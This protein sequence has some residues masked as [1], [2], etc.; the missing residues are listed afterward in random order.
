MVLLSLA[1]INGNAQH[2]GFWRRQTKKHFN[3]INFPVKVA[4]QDKVSFSPGA[5]GASLSTSLLPLFT[6]YAKS[7]AFIFSPP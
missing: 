4:S 7:F 6:G 5:A 2:D 3:Y 1:R